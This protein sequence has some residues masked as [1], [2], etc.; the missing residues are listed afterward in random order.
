[1]PFTFEGAHRRRAAEQAIENLSANVDTLITI[2]N[3]RLLQIADKKTGIKDAF[4]L[5][6]DVLRQGIQGISDL[7]TQR[8]LIN[9]DFADVKTIMAQQGSALMAIGNGS[10]DS[11]MVDAVNEAI[12]SPLL[13][14]SID[15]A[16]GVLINVVGGEDLGILEVYEAA[17][18]IAKAVDPEAQIIFGAVIDPNFPPGQVKLTLIATGFDATRPNV[19]RS[20]AYPAPALNASQPAPQPQMVSVPTAQPQAAQPQRP[21]AQPAPRATPSFSSSDDLDIPPFLR[22]RNRQRGQ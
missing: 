3:D 13:E 20:R 7:I 17:D 6:D 12:A 4:R 18:I 10:G 11:R 14:V 8:G 22:N 9:V 2:P 16:K 21:A 19:Q 5:A 15:G 1:R